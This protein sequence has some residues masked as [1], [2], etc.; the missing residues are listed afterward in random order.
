MSGPTDKEKD[1]QQGQDTQAAALEQTISERQDRHTPSQSA[2][3]DG[4]IPLKEQETDDISRSAEKDEEGL[5]PHLTATKSYATETS[6]ASGPAPSEEPV[7]RS[8]VSKI[9]PLRWGPV[10]PIPEEKVVSKEYGA[11]WWGRLTFSWMT[12]LMTVSGRD[13]FF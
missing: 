5:R 7:K 3:D 13:V 6:V 1:L 8:W 4:E 11:G 10:P 12:P 2:S 9:N